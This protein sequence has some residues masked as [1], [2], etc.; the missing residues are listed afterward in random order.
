LVS[1]SLLLLPI[2]ALLLYYYGIEHF[3]CFLGG[4]MFNMVIGQKILP[5]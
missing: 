5:T 4:I 1:Y 2:G 3:F